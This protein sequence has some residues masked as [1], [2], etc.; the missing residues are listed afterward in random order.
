M[1]WLLARRELLLAVRSRWMQVFA[2]A[3]AVLA[4]SVAASGYVLTGGYGLQDFSRT[5]ASLVE[6]LVLVVPL[7]ALLIGVQA[8]AV[9]PGE[10]ELLFSQPISRTTVLAGRL[11]G[12]WIAFAAA[13][14]F[15][16]GAAGVA[17]Y[18][19]TDEA[20]LVSYAILLAGAIVLAAIF[21]SIAALLAVGVGRRRTRALALSVV[22]WFAAAVVID[23]GALGLATALPSA[24]ASRVLIWATVLNP[25]AAARAALLLAT[26]GSGAFGAASLAL[27]RFARGAG[28]IAVLLGG[29]LAFWLMVPVTLA[30]R[31]LSNSDV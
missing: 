8:L 13:E 3:F 20:G 28:G 25:A 26:E 14:S 18:L 2:V 29:S 22:V 16:L 9:E 24:A 7:A 15:G 5:A 21:L 6:L 27:T 30:A 23:L 10:A 17:V 4:A 19:G 12:L 1:I 11:L 31:R